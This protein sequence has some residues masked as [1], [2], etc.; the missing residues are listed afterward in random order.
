MLFVLNTNIA[1]SSLFSREGNASY[2]NK[3]NPANYSTLLSG[4]LIL[5]ATINIISI[6]ISC[7]VINIG[8]S[9]GA[10]QTVIL[11]L[12]II[13]IYLGHLFWS[14]EF[15]IMNLQNNY[16]QTTGSHHKNPNETKSVILGFICSA[17]FSFITFFLIK[18]DVRNVFYKLFFISLLFVSIRTYLF[19]TKIKL[20]YKEK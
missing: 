5:N 6:I 4:K 8:N 12:S 16:Y 19:Y 14:A 17:I 15:D 13:G 18:E 1:I 10:M 20:Y 7:I 11:A 2:L 9:I 3:V